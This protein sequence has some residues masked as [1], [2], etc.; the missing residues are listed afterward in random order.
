MLSEFQNENKTLEGRLSSIGG[1][2]TVHSDSL[3]T[4]TVF[5]GDQSETT[6]DHAV[7]RP[8]AVNSS[9]VK[10]FIK[11]VPVVVIKEVEVI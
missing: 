11:E 8:H 10:M 3:T 5:D 2:K 4:G 9:I 7:D 1:D 6:V